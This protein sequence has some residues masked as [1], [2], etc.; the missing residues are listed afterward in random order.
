M[1]TLFNSIKIDIISIILAVIT[2]IAII[3]IPYIMIK[4]SESITLYLEAKRDKVNNETRNVILTENIMA[5]KI[6][7][8][9][10]SYSNNLL[11]Y[12]NELIGIY[13]KLKFKS[14][15]DKYETSKITQEHVKK[16]ISEVAVSVNESI[17]YSKIDFNNTMY[18]KDYIN[19]YIV[20][21]TV[22]HIK[23]LVEESILEII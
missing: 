3:I 15:L 19:K 6:K 2:T 7:E 18:T 17:D 22:Y 14:F 8:N 12:I 9:Q 11:K 1:N 4:I 20:E 23:D 16:L 21:T 5:I 13:S 10:L